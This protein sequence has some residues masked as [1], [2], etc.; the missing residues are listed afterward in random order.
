MQSLLGQNGPVTVAGPSSIGAAPDAAAAHPV[1]ISNVSASVEAGK[2]LR[3]RF[4]ITNIPQR[5]T[6]SGNCIVFAIT[7]QG[8]EVE[9]LPVIRG[10]LT[11]RIGRFKAMQAVL[12]L[13]DKV[14]PSDF[15]SLRISVLIDDQPQYW[16]LFPIS[17]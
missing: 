15:V 13:P 17:L 4:G 5:T 10:A 1:Q 9:L 14:S 6:L 12:V 7:K 16:M 8:A 3:I 11:F 2:K